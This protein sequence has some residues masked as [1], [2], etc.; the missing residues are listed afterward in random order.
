LERFEAMQERLERQAW[1][2]KES[3][4]QNVS[5]QSQGQ[6]LMKELHQLIE[7]CKSDSAAAERGETYDDSHRHN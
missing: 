3:R 5:A 1:Q 2:L 6:E 7:Q 4:Y